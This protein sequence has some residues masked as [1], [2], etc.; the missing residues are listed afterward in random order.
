MNKH[1][2]RV[3]VSIG[4]VIAV[5]AGGA[6]ALATVIDPG[7][8][9]A[10]QLTNVGPIDPVNGFPAYYKDSNGVRLEPCGI[11][12]VD[13]TDPFCVPAVRPDT[14]SPVSF[15]GNFPDE[16][17]YEMNKADFDPV[18]DGV[19][20]RVTVDLNLEGSFANGAAVDGD[21]I[22][23]GRVRVTAKT[24]P[25]GTYR[26]VHPYGIDEGV[27]SGGAGMDRIV[28]DVGVAAGA[29]G[30]ALKSR[31]GP[32]LKWDPAVAPAAPAGHLGDGVTAHKVVGSPYGTNY[33]A[34]Q[35]KDP[36]TGNFVELGRTTDIV[37]M[38]RLA[39][40]AGVDVT[41][42]VYTLDAGGKGFLDVY[43]TSEV[44]E[45]VQVQPNVALGTPAVPLRGDANGRYYGR[46][47]ISGDIPANFSI[48]VANVK[49]SPPSVK[50]ARIG[51]LITVTQSAY[52]S[53][54][55]TLTVTATSADVQADA[56]TP[57]LSVDGF[58]PLVAGTATFANVIAPPPGVTVTS[59]HSGSTF[60][61]LDTTGAGM[62]P[63]LPVAAFLADATGQVGRAVTMNASASTGQITGWAWTVTGPA[64]PAITGQNT[65]IATWTPTVA[66]TYTMN[67]TVSGP[68]GASL[69][70]SRTIVVSGVTALTANA[71]PAQT[72]RR[73]NTVT[74]NGSGSTGYTSL[75]WS[76]VSGPAVTI[77]GATTVNPTFVYPTMALPT[78]ANV[79]TYV[80]NNAP[81]VM[82]L[83]ATG[84]GGATATA[85]V[86]ISPQPETFTIVTSRYRTGNSIWRIDGSSSIAAGQNVAFVLANANGTGKQ[87]IG[88]AI[89]DPALGAFS[90]R[91]GPTPRP[92]N[93]QVVLIY[94]ATGGTG[95]AAVSITN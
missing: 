17:F 75:L 53:D 62:L 82:K 86:T 19:A 36:V 70:F 29:F 43:A 85:Q 77:N 94:S 69:P 89:A 23:F 74:L 46:V 30:G 83:T 13:T 58:G 61:P 34:L 59:D 21:Q 40:K 91:T 24:L 2:T 71:G 57:K 1:L 88:T 95:Q 55:Q 50:H 65:S 7:T 25:D 27:A 67:L 37:V 56:N 32:F 4:A 66:G 9:R 11:D 48:D 81:V 15:P 76:R 49:D 44:G 22:T 31:V 5:V 8:P 18:V 16:F 26:I 68:G 52:N 6:G 20:R 38:G 72:V 90:L 87:F 93:G 14:T 42:A 60:R 39:T 84:A 35:R 79:G 45:V 47:A 41:K 64:S 54:A 12:P 51:D 80:P 78:A 33:V 28:D 10:G 92:V 73:G 3:A 63:S